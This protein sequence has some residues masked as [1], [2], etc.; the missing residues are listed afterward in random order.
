MDVMDF[1]A[2]DKN[3]SLQ[4]YKHSHKHTYTDILPETISDKKYNDTKNMHFIFSFQLLFAV[5]HEYMS[6]LWQVR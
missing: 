1:V 3:I 4:T 6:P 2:N 5:K